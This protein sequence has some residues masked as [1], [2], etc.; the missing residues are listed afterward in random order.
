MIVI[1]RLIRR[2]FSFVPWFLLRRINP[3]KHTNK[4]PFHP[5]LSPYLAENVTQ[6]KSK[7][8]GRTSHANALN[9]H[10]NEQMK[11]YYSEKQTH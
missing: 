6:I 2:Q 10:T 11:H 7:Q 1:M 4:V 8:R 3:P 5:L 9:T